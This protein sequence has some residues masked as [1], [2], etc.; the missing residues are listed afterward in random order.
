MCPRS[1]RS[2][3]LSPRTQLLASPAPCRAR[4]RSGGGGK[5]L[6][7]R[8]AHSTTRPGPRRPGPAAG[9]GGGRRGRRRD[10]G[11]RGPAR[12]RAGAGGSW[13]RRVPE[14][15]GPR[16]AAR[17]AA[18]RAGAG[19]ALGGR[20]VRRRGRRAL[21]RGPRPSEGGR[22]GSFPGLQRLA[23]LQAPTHPSRPRTLRVP[24]RPDMT[25]RP[26]ECP[27][28]S[29]AE[30]CGNLG[31]LPG[32][33]VLVE[34]FIYSL[35]NHTHVRTLTRP[36]QACFPPGVCACDP[37]PFRSVTF[38]LALRKPGFERVS[39]TEG[40]VYP[41]CAFGYNTFFIPTKRER[42]DFFFLSRC[43]VGGRS[44]WL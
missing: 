5:G 12:K 24:S 9:K 19:R 37:R 41:S 34:L 1:A 15:E 28:V 25:S 8:G 23:G 10:P 3:R 16:R 32:L 6:R 26:C 38:P 44:R 13:E 20:G 39:Q 14:E 30:P 11:R 42:E 7:T 21:A 29:Q 33:V 18:T 35:P 4:E 17:D 43:Q 27:A 22:R 40:R 31:R 36:G 2:L